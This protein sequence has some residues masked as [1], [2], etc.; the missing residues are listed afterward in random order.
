MFCAYIY[1]MS[2][3]KGIEPI[4]IQIGAQRLTAEISAR[5]TKKILLQIR[6]NKL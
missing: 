2:K 5:Q 3:A 4:T 1:V 6:F